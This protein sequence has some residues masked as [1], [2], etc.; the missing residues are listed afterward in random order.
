[1]ADLTLAQ[2]F[3]TSVAFDPATK[4][5]SINLNDLSNLTISGVDY[6]LNVTA[7]SAANKD[8]Y[9]SKILWALLLKSTATQPA[10][11]NDATVGVYI[12]NQG[13]RNVVRNSIN[14]FGYQLAATAYQADNLGINLD[15]DAVGA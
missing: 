10:D 7:M 6:G 8:S 13:K 9:A 2:R 5:L 11:N 15:P 3:G 14:Q 4:I 1:M 12:T